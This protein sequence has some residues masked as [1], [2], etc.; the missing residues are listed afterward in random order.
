MEKFTDKRQK[1]VKAL[2]YKIFW[3]FLSR[4]TFFR[5]IDAA[6]CVMS[7]LLY[8]SKCKNSTFSST[9][10]NCASGKSNFCLTFGKIE[11]FFRYKISSFSF[12]TIICENPSELAAT[13]FPLKKLFFW[14]LL[15]SRQFSW[16][17]DRKKLL[18]FKKKLLLQLF[19][20]C[21]QALNIYSIRQSRTVYSS[22]NRIIGTFLIS[23]DT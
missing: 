11:L 7:T 12:E 8:Q 6:L 14:L 3:K 1:T 17:I 9:W 22:I 2:E 10:L 4:S 5:L 20:T 15:L 13:F 23:S 18:F 16:K 19:A 21:R